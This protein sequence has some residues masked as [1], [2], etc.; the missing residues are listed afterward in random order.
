[1]DAGFLLWVLLLAR[2]LLSEADYNSLCKEV[3]EAMAQDFLGHDRAAWLAA[4]GVP[5][6]G[7]TAPGLAQVAMAAIPLPSGV[8]DHAEH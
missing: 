4:C 1:M 2:S 3:S 6:H 7:K 5:S 8:T